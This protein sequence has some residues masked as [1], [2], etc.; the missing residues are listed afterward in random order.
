MA[1]VSELWLGR[2]QL[3]R[4]SC[5]PRP[6]VATSL[7]LA[8]ASLLFRRRCSGRKALPAIVQMVARQTAAHQRRRGMA[9]LFVGKIPWYPRDVQKLSA[10]LGWGQH[11]RVRSVKGIHECLAKALTLRSRGT[12]RE[13]PRK[14]GYLH[15][16]SHTVMRLSI[17]VLFGLFA[18]DVAIADDSSCS[19]FAKYRNSPASPTLKRTSAEVP[20]G[21]FCPDKYDRPICSAPVIRLEDLAKLG[22][23]LDD[24]VDSQLLNSSMAGIH[25]SEID[26]DNDGIPEL[27]MYSVGGS[28]QC[29]YSWFYKKGADGKYARMQSGEYAS[30][31]EDRPILSGRSSISTVRWCRLRY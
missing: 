21:T 10:L 26:I 13:K 2:L 24:P 25:F 18:I 3:Q 1:R 12:S 5:V 31:S 27:R 14:A 17:F 19:Y 9:G 4:G 23:P 22:F 28:A 6:K 29:T 16:R 11:A 7:C 30:L 8:S 20:L 15:V